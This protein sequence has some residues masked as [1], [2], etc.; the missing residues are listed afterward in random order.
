M[1]FLES[2]VITKLKVQDLWKNQM[3]LSLWKIHPGNTT[4]EVEDD[5]PQLG[6]CLASIFQGVLAPPPPIARCTLIELV[7]VRQFSSSTARLFTTNVNG[8]RTWGNNHISGY[9]L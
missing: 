7:T 3:I 5:F 4:M 1:N 8:S 6:R 9:T 2:E